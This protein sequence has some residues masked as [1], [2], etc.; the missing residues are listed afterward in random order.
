LLWKKVLGASSLD[1]QILIAVDLPGYG[2]SEGLNTYSASEVLEAMSE[3]ILGMREK[4]LKEEAKM[5][6]VTHDWGAIIGARLAAEASQLAD[7]WVIA[8]VLIVGL[9][10]FSPTFE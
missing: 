2:G 4:F 5:V 7:R 1:P 10:L 3:F 9:P 8:S 6:V